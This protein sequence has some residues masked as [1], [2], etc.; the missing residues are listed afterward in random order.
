MEIQ[1]R[2]ILTFVLSVAAGFS[3][4]STAALAGGPD[5]DDYPLRV[6]I[7][8][9]NPRASSS[10]DP[11][12]LGGVANWV[13]GSGA[14]D[15]YE[16]SEPRGLLFT[17]SCIEGARASSDYETFPARWKKKEK[18]LEILLP[19]PGKPWN[20]VSCNLQA[21]MRDGLAFYWND[22]VMEEEPAAKYKEWMVKHQFDPEKGKEV[23]MDDDS[24]PSDSGSS[25]TSSSA[26][27]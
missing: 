8:R 10:R 25:G 6:Q 2:L 16:N 15:L 1:M 17:Y 11:S 3:L 26:P 22:G 21:E 20:R 12:K 18:T 13:E 9:I 5:P 27:R 7:L 24:G 4:L 23:P 14:A 19:Q